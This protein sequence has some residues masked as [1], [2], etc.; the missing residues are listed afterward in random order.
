M[1]E[2]ASA[3][4]SI[5]GESDREPLATVLRDLQRY[6]ELGDSLLKSSTARRIRS[7]EYGARYDALGGHLNAPQAQATRFAGAVFASEALLDLV[8]APLPGGHG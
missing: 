8:R 1:S 2:A 3:Y 6:R 4:A 7:R 5:A